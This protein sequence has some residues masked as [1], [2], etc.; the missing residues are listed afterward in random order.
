MH[1]KNIR[2][3]VV[4]VLCFLLGL[5]I[6]FQVKT[7]SKSNGTIKFKSINELKKQIELE[8]TEIDNHNQMILQKRLEFYNYNKELE[9]TGSIVETLENEKKKKMMVS[10]ILPVSG[11]GIL[12]RVSD[13]KKELKEGENP[14]D[15][16]VHDQDILHILNDLRISGAEAIS[17]SGERVSM[18]SEIKCNGPTI[19]INDRT[20]GQP[21]LIGA[22]GNQEDLMNAIKDPESY[23][24]LLRTVY[25]LEIE[26]SSISY[27]VIPGYRRTIE[28]NYMKE[29]K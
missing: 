16:I 8:K 4:M 15:K 10:G 28:L 22:I 18:L 1:R 7:V 6:A 5:I 12:I 14:N 13:S 17:I 29:A 2:V 26:A 21:F 3:N 24:Y 20:Y 19:T 9:E 27:L 11:E 23:S 25:G